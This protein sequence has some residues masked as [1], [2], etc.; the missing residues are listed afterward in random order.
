LPQIK[1]KTLRLLKIAAVLIAVSIFYNIPL[2]SLGNI[3]PPCL[4]KRFFDIEC[5]GCG[6]TRAIWC[7]LHFDF[8]KAFEYNKIAVVITFPLL[9][10]LTAAWIFKDNK[11]ARAPFLT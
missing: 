11:K 7:I 5:I 8:N 10:I 3:V 1:P 9:V 4:W 2:E 6:T